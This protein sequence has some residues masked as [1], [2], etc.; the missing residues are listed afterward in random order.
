MIQYSLL[1]ALKPIVIKIIQNILKTLKI[2]ML[3]IQL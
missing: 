1:K 2:K 3:L